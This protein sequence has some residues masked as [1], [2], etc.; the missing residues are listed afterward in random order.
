MVS[1]AFSSFLL[2]WKGAK[3]NVSVIIDSNFDWQMNEN[4]SEVTW[5]EGITMS[6]IEWTKQVKLKAGLLIMNS[7]GCRYPFASFSCTNITN[8]STPKTFKLGCR[9]V[10]SLTL[11]FHFSEDENLIFMAAKLRG[12]VNGVERIKKEKL[13]NIMY[14]FSKWEKP[15]EKRW[16]FGV[17]KIIVINFAFFSHWIYKEIS[18][19]QPR[20]LM[21]HSGLCV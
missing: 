8:S 20:R 3:R 19:C 18:K 17:E 2:T 14:P 13:I 12:E 4:E 21:H 9:T 7:W 16:H 15:M 5:P 1:F 11:K 10:V 6:V